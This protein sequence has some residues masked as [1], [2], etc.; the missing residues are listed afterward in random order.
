VVLRLPRR[1]SI[2]FLQFCANRLVSVDSKNEVI[3]WSLET[4][5]KL[6][7]FSPPGAITSLV[8]DPG[9]DWAFVGLQSGTIVCYDLDRERQAPLRLPNFWQERSPRSR[10]L[11]VVCMQLHP[12]DIGQLLIGYT[13]G[14][15]IY[16]F[17]QNKPV[18]F[19][20]YVVPPGAPGGDSN[21]NNLD[22][23]HKPRLTH[24]LWHPSGTFVA[25]AYD[26]A[27]LVFWD[28]TDGRILMARTLADTHIDRPS[29]SRNM[30]M[31]LKDPYITIA[32]CCKENPD[33]TGLL[34]A[35]GL[36]TSSPMKGM[37]FLELGQP[38]VYTTSSWQMLSDHFQRKR[39]HI[40]PTPEGAEIVDFCLIPRRSPH[41]AGAHDPI[42]VICLLSSGELITLTF[43]SGH[44]LSP[45]NQLHPSL[46]FVHPFVTSVAVASVDR[47]RW[48]GMTETRQ[49]GPPILRGGAEAKHPL[50]RYE[51]RNIV[52][53]A[54]GD[55]T[56]RIFDVGHGD[57]LENSAV[58]QLDVARALGRFENVD[59]TTMSMAG[60]TGEVAVGTMNGEVIIYRWGG[61]QF[62]GRES[63][64]R[65]ETK[66]GGITMIGDRSEPALK[67]G[68]QPFALYDGDQGSIS[69]VKMSDV[70]FVGVGT[71]S[72][73]FSVVDM[74]GPAVIY[75]GS[76]TG[77]SS[78]SQ[79]SGGFLRRGHDRKASTTAEWPVVIEFGVMTLEGDDYSS[80]LCFVGTNTGR[81]STFKILPQRGG[82]TA[83]AAGSTTLSGRVLS[84]SPIV[85][86]TGHP[87]SA[88]GPVVAGLREG[89][90]TDGVLV[91]AT[92]S[93]VRIF[94]PA[95]AKGAHKSFDDY[96]CEAANVT[97]FELHGHAIVG[98]FGDG[99]T[100]AF[101]IPALKEIGMA[102]LPQLDKGRISS[103]IV[104]HS[105]DIVGWTG[106][107][108]LAL[109]NVWGTGKEL[110][111]SQDRLY[112]PEALM[113]PRPTISNLQWIAGTQYIS[114]TDL[115]LLIGGP[116]RPPSRRM[117]ALAAEESRMR[118]GPTR[119][120]TAGTAAGQ[121]GWGD[122]AARQLAERTEKLGIMGDSVEKVCGHV[123]W[124]KRN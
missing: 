47:S 123:E 105:G 6:A 86:S 118:S 94:K 14:V 49:Q 104:T 16:S 85:A 34:I 100:R 96:F 57:E 75:S 111:P 13:E 29:G 112:N 11:N 44:P 113:P 83:A 59:I 114:P 25:T 46:V 15:V 41:F 93:E 51:A 31:E 60:S 12:K 115:D 26:D 42:A 102:R 3:I 88:T 120:G 33:D 92:E 8:T 4:S 18:Q 24:A 20:E 78:H 22:K 66:K 64:Q 61:N 103:T 101:S 35:G 72:G 30:D 80:I 91:V 97:H 56:V 37:T 53:M 98:I 117:M 74:R 43:P 28:A 99:T 90:R 58:L 52:Q 62:Y 32:W 79:K 108:E 121:E 19:F 77:S 106:P 84:I 40:I 2:R 23:S 107:S 9:L 70:G 122:W 45:T 65:A 36:P 1:A 48:L 21:P 109:L 119:A 54:H 69:A 7:A 124:I 110:P 71:E 68:L 116:D 67:E 73:F 38:P 50:R 76:M 82:F 17:K 95:A 10:L 81:V 63:A 55:G 89:R 5:Q 39:Q 87:A 27:S